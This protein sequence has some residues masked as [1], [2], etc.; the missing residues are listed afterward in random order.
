MASFVIFV[1]SPVWE[2]HYDP[3]HRS[4]H[5]E[6]RCAVRIFCYIG[7]PFAYPVPS[8]RFDPTSPFGD[9]MLF[10]RTRPRDEQRRRARPASSDIQDFP[11]YHPLG[12]AGDA[13]SVDTPTHVYSEGSVPS[14]PVCWGVGSEA[15]VQQQPR[16]M[17]RERQPER[18]PRPR[19]GS[20][21]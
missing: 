7:R 15:T 18:R 10:E 13:R 17:R 21:S 4:Y 3:D 6:G 19:S 20:R 8:Y 5:F 14:V 1:D 12:H 16:P 2:F 9:S 11:D